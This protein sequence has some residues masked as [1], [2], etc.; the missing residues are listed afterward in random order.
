MYMSIWK[1][2]IDSEKF[3]VGIWQ[4]F[5]GTHQSHVVRVSEA[6]WTQGQPEFLMQPCCYR[7][8]LS[9]LL[10]SNNASSWL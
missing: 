7:Y 4:C 8:A 3:Y 2:C 5:S 6:N 1:V 9:G 10:Y